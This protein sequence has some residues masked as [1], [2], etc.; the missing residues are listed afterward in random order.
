MRHLSRCVKQVPVRDTLFIAGDFKSL[1]SRIPRLV[2][3]SLLETA[4]S[5]PDESEL[6]NFLRAHHVVALNT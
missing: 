2:G 6:T 3:P 1:V 5:R 4:E